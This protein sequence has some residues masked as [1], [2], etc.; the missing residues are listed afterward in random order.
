ML[1]QDNRPSVNMLMHAA[2]LPDNVLVSPDN[3]QILVSRE[4]I[5][6]CSNIV[7]AYIGRNL[8]NGEAVAMKKMME[9]SRGNKYADM[10]LGDALHILAT[11][12]MH[13]MGMLPNR[14][15][16]PG[17]QTNETGYQPGGLGSIAM[18]PW[19]IEAGTRPNGAI[20]EPQNALHEY[21]RAELEQL[22]KDE[23]PYKM[24][25]AQNRRGDAVVDRARVSGHNSSP[26]DIP[27]LTQDAVQRVLHDSHSAL[28]KIIDPATWP[29]TMQKFRDSYPRTLLD[30]NLPHQTVM[31]DSRNCDPVRTAVGQ[32]GWNIH[33][34]GNV[35]AVGNVRTNDTLQQIMT[36]QFGDFWI[37]LNPNSVYAAY[38]RIQVYIPEFGAQAI[39][40]LSWT[41]PNTSNQA[42]PG[43]Y[44]LNFDITEFV[45]GRAH[46]VPNRDGVY[47]L[48]APHAVLNSFTVQFTVMNEPI[49]FDPQFAEMNMTY[50]NPTTLT[51]ALI[52]HQLLT[53]DLVYIISSNTG[54]A[55]ID[56]ELMRGVGY[57]IIV[58]DPFSFTIPVDTSTLAG[59]QL[60]DVYFGSK[61]ISFDVLFTSIEQ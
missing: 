27:P 34:A 10:A 6:V 19:Q 23:T 33:T 30:I 1:R 20:E 59:S 60:V 43:N 38:S 31:F 21:Q 46:L 22:T 4:A 36:F 51:A 48:R 15:G 18:A 8:R 42:F 11:D 35:G 25:Y 41:N 32:F 44:H 45:A 16:R 50:G 14:G 24:N 53:G 5:L 54:S 39:P 28:L 40:T 61:R 12:Y 26:H 57:R 37:P 9:A 29:E 55:A 7:S 13:Q 17:P 2:G 52:P 56:R 47:K 49:V 3:Y 58:L